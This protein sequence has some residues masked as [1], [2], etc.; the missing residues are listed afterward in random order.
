MLSHISQANSSI[1]RDLIEAHKGEMA[2]FLNRGE[3]RFFPEVVLS[4][5]L[6]DGTGDYDLLAEMHTELHKGKTW[7]KR[8]N[9]FHFSV[10]QNKTKN[11]L[12]SYS[13]VPKI[14][15]INIAHIKF[16][17]KEHVIT[18]IDGNHRLSAADEVTDD[19]DTPFCLL[20]FQT[21]QE[22]EQ[23]SRAIFHNINAKQIP[24][25]LEENLKVI[26]TSSEVFPDVKLINDPSFGWQYYL[27]RKII[28]EI[29]FSYFPLIY[30]FIGKTQY[31]F[32]V[33]LFSFLIRNGSVEEND[34][35][36]SKVKS[37]L[38]NIEQALSESEI[39]GTTNNV[40]V[41]GAL[42][43][44]KLTNLSKY[45]GFLSWVKRNNIGNVDMLHIG[46]VINLY[47]E[48]YEHVPKKA[49][50]ARWY[51]DAEKDGRDE[52]DKAKHRIQ[53]MQAV[54]DE[55]GLDL[56]D[57]GTRE[58]GTFDI[59]EVMYRD[60]RECDI[61]IADLSG[62]RHNVMIEVGYALKYVEA[63]RMLFYFQE[64]DACSKVP[65]DVNHLNYVPIVDSG[66]IRSKVKDRVQTILTQAKNGE[67]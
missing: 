26:L 44:Y 14:E 2:I 11:V 49:F 5:N 15:I 25:M 29:D 40:A 18:R 56:T 12:G 31:S 33:E 17:E 21:A 32:F 42:A 28:N 6:T 48:I 53:A 52:A 46:D 50:L 41:I 10:S 8:I 51:P 3:Y 35:A 64:S 13:P 65:F 43:Y 59:R 62:A 24:L 7:N 60:I 66:D 57:L 45:S 58:T 36:I 27:S 22:N 38:T 4:L 30:T 55:L 23:F 39:A 67:I 37:E 61:F 63:G 9:G 20:L 19:F 54:A 16:D 1:Q 34:G 47:D